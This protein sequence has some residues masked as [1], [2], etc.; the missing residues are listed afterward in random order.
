MIQTKA[1]Y[2]PKT[3]TGFDEGGKWPGIESA[4]EQAQIPI[5]GVYKTEVVFDPSIIITKKIKQHLEGAP[6]HFQVL[7][8]PND[9][10][11]P[12]QAS[13]AIIKMT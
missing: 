4:I 13:C 9:V 3:E 2:A 8:D 11:L 6:Y 5:E 10:L 12:H 7:G 1:E